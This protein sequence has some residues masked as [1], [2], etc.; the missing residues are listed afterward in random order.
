MVHPTDEVEQAAACASETT[1]LPGPTAAQ[2][3]SAEE[4]EEYLEASTGIAKSQAEEPDSRRAD[5]DSHEGLDAIKAAETM[6]DQNAFKQVPKPAAAEQGSPDFTMSMLDK[7]E[8]AAELE[9]QE[10]QASEAAMEATE[11][12]VDA[13]TDSA[14]GGPAK[15]KIVPWI[16][17]T[18]VMPVHNDTPVPDEEEQIANLKKPAKHASSKKKSVAPEEEDDEY[19][20]LA[21]EKAKSTKAK[22]KKSKEPE[23]DEASGDNPGGRLL[24]K[25]II[26]EG[27][28]KKKPF[29]PKP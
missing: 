27:E 20:D 3:D 21:E 19:L 4:Q 26:S 2:Q 6:H 12:P 8:V 1:E 28:P 25:H 10:E 15:P 29:P 14:A 22:G 23:E 13:E 9:R 5:D 11:Q 17:P 7:E 18:G 24:L 16:F